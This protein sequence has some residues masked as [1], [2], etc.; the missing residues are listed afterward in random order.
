MM[1]RPEQKKK[2]KEAIKLYKKKAEKLK[3]HKKTAMKV[4]EV[5]PPPPPPAPKS[6]LDHVIEM[7]KKGA[8]FLL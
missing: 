3:Y 4:S 2:Y 7:S 5:P 1:Q 8:V 6:P